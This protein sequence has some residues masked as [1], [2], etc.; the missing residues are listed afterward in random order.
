ME[1]GQEKTCTEA[2][3]HESIF[4]EVHLCRPGGHSHLALLGAL[5]A[6]GQRCRMHGRAGLDFTC[7][8]EEFP[9]LPK[10]SASTCQASSQGTLYLLR[11]DSGSDS[12][13]QVALVMHELS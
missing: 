3:R 5:V 11:R 1:N 7:L 2:Y 10:P 4:P 13:V 6:G 8:V 9:H 12:N